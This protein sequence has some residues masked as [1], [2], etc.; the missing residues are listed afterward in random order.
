VVFF[1]TS[2]QSQHRVAVETLQMMH[3]KSP[4]LV[5]DV[6]GKRDM[7]IRKDKPE[8]SA[9]IHFCAEQIKAGK[10]SFHQKYAKESYEEA[11]KQPLHVEELVASGMREGMCPYRVAMD[12]MEHADVVVCDYNYLF[13]D[14]LENVL[15]RMNRPLG[16]IIAVVD[17]AHNLPDRIRGQHSMSLHPFLVGEAFKECR[18]NKRL[19]HYLMLIQ[20]IFLDFSEEG[21]GK[22]AKGLLPDMMEGVLKAAI[23]PLTYDEFADSLRQVGDKKAMIGEPSACI[24]LADFLDLWVTDFDSTVR[25]YRG[26]ERPSLIYR[27]LD[28]SHMAR[29]IFDGIYSSLL[30][31]GTLF[32]MKMYRDLLGLEPRRTVLKEYSSPFPKKNRPVLVDKTATTRYNERGED[33]YCLIADNLRQYIGRVPGNAAVFFQSYGL[34]NEIGN[35]LNVRPKDRWAETPEMTK[36]EKDSLQGRLMRTKKEKGMVVLGVMGASLAEGIDYKDNALDM[37][38]VVGLPLAPPTLETKLV[39][40][41]YT[42]LFGEE[43]G[44]YYG[45]IQPAMNKVLQ[46]SGRAIR[47]SEDRAMVLLLDKRFVWGR[48][49]KC[50][51]KDFR[52]WDEE[53][54]KGSVEEFFALVKEE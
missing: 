28:P 33:M 51:P 1:L 39:I 52:I 24:E 22:V 17:E 44:E 40:E 6:V 25:L 18:G 31:S 10:C 27:V 4:L 34:L 5:V 13:S 41:F 53:D 26:G 35:R 47:S 30:M 49:R 46:A 54:I 37:V 45:Y 32:P 50:F 29:P 23:D 48:Y 11:F 19:Q 7:C 2:R 42:S 16:D 36:E 15:A 14:L 21:E 9:F 38:A 3:E 43:E 12:L 8:G 20:D